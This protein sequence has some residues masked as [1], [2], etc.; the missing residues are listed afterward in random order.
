MTLLTAVILFAI[1]PWCASD[2]V[3]IK[4]SEI[5]EGFPQASP[6]DALPSTL[7]KQ[8]SSSD[9]KSRVLEIIPTPSPIPTPSFPSDESTT[10]AAPLKKT[11]FVLDN[12]AL[13][14]YIKSHPEPYVESYSPAPIPDIESL[15][16]QLV[17]T[18]SPT[19]DTGVIACSVLVE[20]EKMNDKWKQM[21]ADLVIDYQMKN[22][23]STLSLK[24][25]EGNGECVT[26]LKNSPSRESLPMKKGRYQ[27]TGT[28]WL[29]NAPDLEVEAAMGAIIIHNRMK[30]TLILDRNVEEE[31]LH[32]IGIRNAEK[33]KRLENQSPNAVNSPED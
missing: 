32:E 21:E 23:Y 17:A 5:F 29:P 4:P 33:L 2:V 7:D 16:E 1:S 11:M 26:V 8:S 30:Y 3:K 18:P 28:F 12:K 19:P 20:V 9:T 10:S 15:R 13:E 6:T 31:I 24:G 22:L 27:I 25:G 14:E